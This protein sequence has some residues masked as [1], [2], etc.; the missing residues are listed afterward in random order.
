MTFNRILHSPITLSDGTSLPQGT[1][2]AVASDA[3][4]NDITRVP[5]ASA[6]DMFSPFRY[7]DSDDS[8]S[9]QHIG[10]MAFH[11]TTAQ[12]M[13]FGYGK[14]AC[15]GR[16]YAAAEIKL[17]IGHLITR[18]DFKFPDGAKR[19]KNYTVDTDMYPDLQ[20]SLLMRKRRQHGE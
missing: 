19:P 6:P 2:L 20:A 1:R 7:V 4:V 5:G 18:Y 15:P 9:K 14:Y 16:F 10:K 3:L 8:V 13:A 11:A 17:V 12:N